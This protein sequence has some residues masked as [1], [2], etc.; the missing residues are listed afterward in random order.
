VIGG[1]IPNGDALDSILVGY[2]DGRDFV[3]VASVRAGIPPVSRR[4][5]LP[6]FEELHK[7]RC[8]FANLPERTEGRWGE[9]LCSLSS[10]GAGCPQGPQ[11]LGSS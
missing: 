2:Y 6:R 1:Y 7:P 3:Y 8:P 5:L 9:R 10:P 11:P 4:V